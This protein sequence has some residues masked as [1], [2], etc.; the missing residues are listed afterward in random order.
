[1]QP[2]PVG[3]SDFKKLREADFAFVDKS[4]LIADILRSGAEVTL[5]PRP[6]RFGKTLNLSMLRYFLDHRNE[7]RNASL[8]EGLQVTAHPDVMKHQGRYPVVFVTFKDIKY[9]EFKHCESAIAKTLGHLFLDH[10]EVI[11]RADPKGVVKK[12]TEAI[13]DGTA[14]FVDLSDALGLLTKLIE[15]GTGKKPIVLF[16][17]YDAPIHAG[18]RHGYYDRIIEFMRNLLSGAFKDNPHLK[19]GVVTGIL[20]VSKESIFSGFNNADVQ[21]IL[22]NSYARYFGFTEDE[23]SAFLARRG[24][25]DREEEVRTWYNG[26]RFGGQ[27]IYNPWSIMKMAANPEAPLQP[28]WVNTSD[29]RLIQSLITDER[30][31]RREDLEKLLRGELLAKVL[32][33]DIV[34]NKMT[35]K[36]VW[37][38]LTLSGY[39]KTE[40]LVIDEGRFKSELTIPN[41]EVRLFYEESV[42][43]WVDE[44]SGPQG[45]SPLIEALLAQDMD[46]L[47]VIFAEVVKSVLSY[48][49]T[50]GNEP[51]RVYH[52]FMLG[53]L[54]AL[55][56]RYRVVSNRESGFGRYDIIMIPEDERH[57]G[58]VFE[59]KR[60]E[61][62]PPKETAKE[63]LQQIIEREYAVELQAAGIQS[64]R[65][66]GIAVDGKK[67]EIC[68]ALLSP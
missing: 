29:N 7:T 68:S 57:T 34:M 46:R 5:L 59:F 26:Y 58:I 21:T 64:I 3:I 15:E 41:K 16:D 25:A 9:S 1:M 62:K 50:A 55:R 11:T 24:L 33:V 40:T 60:V 67:T 35:A 27:I 53:L 12:S 63:A 54:V 20:R 17:E 8:F 45:F 13:M 28:Y 47:A 4:M 66:V 65:A 31:V 48:H 36:A 51:E 22:D 19:T 37:S 42:R 23:V 49:D 44:Q 52:A 10:R 56:G 18:Y 61:E 2:I 43:T 39:L 14:D 30:A 38:M 6:R 32:D